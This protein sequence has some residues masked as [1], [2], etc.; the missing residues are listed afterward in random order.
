MFQR[1]KNIALLSDA[2]YIFTLT[3]SAGDHDLLVQ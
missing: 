2:L 1:L 3:V